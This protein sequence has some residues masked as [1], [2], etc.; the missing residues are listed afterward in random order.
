M[1]FGHSLGPSSEG[2]LG[3]KCCNIFSAYGITASAGGRAPKLRDQRG[4]QCSQ[5]GALCFTA[6]GQFGRTL[7]LFSRC[8]VV[9]DPHLDFFKVVDLEMSCLGSRSKIPSSNI[10]QVMTLSLFR[11]FSVFLRNH[12]F[13]SISTNPRQYDFLRP[14]AGTA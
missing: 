3:A 6:S 4:C 8:L 11:P 9:F 7:E 12:L 5:G 13:G 1:L 14:T 2:P 10:C